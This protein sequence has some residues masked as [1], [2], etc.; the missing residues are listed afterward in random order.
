MNERPNRYH[1]YLT[2]TTRDASMRLSLR[3]LSCILFLVV[4]PNVTRGQSSEPLQHLWEIQP[5]LGYIWNNNRLA[6]SV[7]IDFDSLLSDQSQIRLET[8]RRICVN[9]DRPGFGDKAK[10]IERLLR[11]LTRADE[12]IL[13]RR[14][15]TSAA[16][17]LDDGTHATKLWELSRNDPVSNQEVQKALIRWRSDAA[18][19][20]WRKVVLNPSSPALITAIAIE[21]L[22]NV[23]T[24]EDQKTLND[25][26]ESESASI[27]LRS[28]A[29]QS[30]GRIQS[31]GLS[32]LAR[33]YLESNLPGKDT[34]AA[35]L[36]I[37]HTDDE[38]LQLL[39]SVH[40]K[41][42]STA[43]RIAATCLARESPKIAEELMNAW[44]S[45]P[46]PYFRELAIQVASASEPSKTLHVAS[47]MLHDDEDRL[48]N[49]ARLRLLKLA[50]MH[51]EEID[52]I[53]QTELEGND[54][55]GMEQAI[56]LLAEL[57]DASKCERLLELFDH[58][59][60]EV[61]MHAA[62]ALRD[63]SQPG[64]LLDRIRE[65]AFSLTDSLEKGTRTFGKSEIIMLSLTL[66][67]F[68]R[69]KHEPALAILEKYIP[70]NDFKMGNLA[71]CSAIWSIGQIR[72]NSNDP[73]LRAKLRERIKDL[74]PDKPE[75]YLVRFSCILA[76]GEF[77]FEDSWEVI[78]QYSG[79]PPG[80][81]GHAGIW[82]KEQI[83][84][85]GK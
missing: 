3:T 1:H 35:Y 37:Q 77:G 9:H 32:A 22:G 14:T 36:L 46:D 29:A 43:K 62:W 71:R 19:D 58:P 85:S 65:K 23:G 45:D 56:I 33:K 50:S 80:P 73:D 20:Y 18:L 69:H 7:S 55:K 38:S 31:S 78:E 15:F 83:K 49:R 2:R 34:I 26:L 54:W 64:P 13:N 40:D 5:N 44:K 48:R 63:L 12:S 10:A 8:A 59:Q 27:E 81:L 72:K 41:G 75:N 60:A 52:A 4:A 57:R 61:H 53:I 17:L 70:K 47:S 21:G 68:G 30:L 79:S 28:L 6:Q 74:P 24:N 76:L 82:A 84:K 51:R 67:T 66:E 25:I 16:C 42:T 39:R 11:A